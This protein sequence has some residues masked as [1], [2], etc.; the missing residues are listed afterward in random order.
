MKYPDFIEELLLTKAYTNLT[1]KEKLQ[2]S[3]WVDNEE[4]YTQIRELLLGIEGAFGTEE[5]EL[6]PAHIQ[7]TLEQAFAKKYKAKRMLTI[8][9]QAVAMLT[10]AASLALIFYVGSLFQH[11]QKPTEIAMNEAKKEETITPNKPKVENLDNEDLAATESNNQSTEQLKSLPQ[12]PAISEVDILEDDFEADMEKYRD[13]SPVE[14][15]IREPLA[16]DEVVIQKMV[17]KV[18]EPQIQHVPEGSYTSPS[19]PI[20]KDTYEL[21]EIKSANKYYSIG[22]TS[23]AENTDLLDL[24]VEVY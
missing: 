4:E 5:E 1:D 10:V 13:I 11:N 2:V 9:W 19:A 20:R 12:P 17:P 18:A 23:L 7:T 15:E 8:R 22:N 24:G 14:K 21:D 3:E 6:V 16:V